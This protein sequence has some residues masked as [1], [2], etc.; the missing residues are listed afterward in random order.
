MRTLSADT[1]TENDKTSNQP[2]IEVSFDSVTNKWSSGTF[3]AITGNHRKEIKDFSYVWPK[4]NLLSHIQANTQAEVT[5]QDVD[6]EFSKDLAGRGTAVSFY[7]RTMTSNYGFNHADVILSEFFT[8]PATKVK[9]KLELIDGFESW[10]LSSRGIFEFLERDLFRSVQTSTLNGADYLKASTAT[11]PLASTSG[12]IDPTA[13][14]SKLTAQAYVVIDQEIIG[15]TTLSS[16]DPAAT[17]TRGMFGTEDTDHFDGAEVRQFYAMPGVLPTDWLLYVLL[18]TDDGS[19]HAYYD[20]AA[21]DSGFNDMGLGLSA[22]EVDIT[23]IER[24][25]YKWYFE[26]ESCHF[27]GSSKVEDSKRWLIENILKP[28]DL[29]LYVNSSNKITVG[30]IDY[31]DIVD[32]GS[33]VT[34]TQAKHQIKSYMVNYDTVISKQRIEYEIDPLSKQHATIA[35]FDNQ[36]VA[37]LHGGADTFFVKKNPL[38]NTGLSNKQVVWTSGRRLFT[39]FE[40]PVIEANIEVTPPNWLAEFYDIMTLE[41]DKIPDMLDT[42]PFGGLGISSLSL[43]LGQQIKPISNP[44]IF[45]YDLPLSG[46]SDPASCMQE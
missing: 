17:I 34:I 8:L 25:G 3:T 5:I 16:G 31:Y 18:T 20:L 28:A 13:L 11:I 2:V 37:A 22:T 41:N 30:I 23:G 39:F 1:N 19:G 43:I 40:N 29:F 4:I 45:S 10:K 33:N 27:I 21:F 42:S 35:E 26:E 46:S 44:R 6:L 7:S 12:W 9:G 36:A 38:L 14:P 32:R 15:Y 24:L